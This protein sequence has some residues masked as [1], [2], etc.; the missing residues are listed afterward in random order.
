MKPRQSK[1]GA[2]VAEGREAVAGEAVSPV[3]GLALVFGLFLGLAILKFGNPVI[4]DEQVGTPRNV[5]EVWSYAWPT[6]WAYWGVI[7]LLA[8]GGYLWMGLMSPQRAKGTP[9][10]AAPPSPQGGEGHRSREGT[11]HQKGTPHPSSGHLLPGAEKGDPMGE[12]HLP[13][14]DKG[15]RWLWVLPVVWLG[16][17][18]VSA[19]QTVDA[20]L[21]RD[22]LWHFGAC[23]GCYLVGLLVLGRERVLPWLLAGILAA[24]AWCLVRAANQR[25]IEFPRELAGEQGGWTNF[26]PELVM[27]L[28]ESGFIIT[29]NGVEVANPVILEKYAKGRVHGTVVYPNALAGLIILLLPVSLVLAVARTGRLRPWIRGCVLVM[30]LFLGLGGLFWTGSKLGWLVG[31]GLVGIWLL[32]LDWPRGLKVAL[33]VCVVAGGLGMFA[34]R[35]QNYFSAGA[36]SVGARFDYWRAAGEIFVRHPVF[37]TGPGTFQR[38]YALVKAPES[39]MARL[40]HNDYLEQFSDSGL[41]GGVAYLA[42]IGLALMVAI[43]IARRSG[44]VVR[45]GVV[46]GLFGWYAQG[47]GEFSLYVPALAWTAFVLLGTIVN[48]EWT[49]MDTKPLKR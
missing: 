10:P 36:K 3:V 38:P 40:A 20:Q 23:V 45:Q 18:L 14:A 46:L 33:I 34:W 32:R 11:P 29:T 37:G 41:I 24:F 7:P 16:W 44:D 6:R 1:G 30:V 42:W 12:G 15:D 39:E 5:N 43:Q 31:L 25:L 9:H 2:H 17:Q 35:F 28:R 49:R 27:Q 19:T 47:V 13:R 26:P 21:T 22:V 8:I 48:H 4:L